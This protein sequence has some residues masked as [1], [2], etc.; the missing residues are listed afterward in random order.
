MM[1][2]SLFKMATVIAVATLLSRFMGYLREALLAARFGATHVTDA[3]VVAQD[4]PSSV[5]AA[6]GAALVMVFIPVFQSVV[7]RRGEEAAMRLVNTVM[8]V[9]LL[10]S[11][12]LMALGWLVAPYLVP[13]LVP[14]LPGGVQALTVSLTRTMMPMMLFMA[15]GGV[16]SAVLNANRRFTAPALVGLVTNLAVVGGLLLIHTPEQIGLVAWAVVAGSAASALIQL[17]LLPGLG[18]RYRPAVDWSDPALKQVGRL[19][20]PMMLTTGAIQLQGF[21]GRFLASHLA[22]GSISAL[23]Y[24]SRMNT[25]PYGVVGAAIATVLYPGLAES[26]AAGREGELRRTMREGLDTLAFVLLPMALGLVFFRNQI[27]H[28]F[29]QRGAFDPR[30]TAATAYAL[31][32]F[33]VGILFSGWLDYLN[34]CFLALQDAVTPMWVAL[35]MLA[36]NLGFNLVLVGPLGHGGLA[37]GT[38]LATAG[39]ALFL[40][41]RLGRRVGL[42]DGLALLQAVGVHL[43]TA[44]FG[45]VAGLAVLHLMKWLMPGMGLI[46]QAV[47]IVAGLGTIV[48]VH[49]ALALSLGNQTATA[50]AGRWLPKGRRSKS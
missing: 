47:R 19:M 39:A 18:L 12:L 17:P 44:V 30:A 27:V 3:Y 43:G 41:W 2:R 15:A 21:V 23:N 31:Q 34:R 24:A 22:E 50:L 33:A 49:V 20:L 7:Q 6:L 32:F 13:M 46:S 45:T 14:G 42:G 4:I 11:A 40:L 29:F 10:I 37:L 48:V 25:L 26:A 8:N 1:A 5:L 16:A 36:L 9:S 38:S 28:L 35:G